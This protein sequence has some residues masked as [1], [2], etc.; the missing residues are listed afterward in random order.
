MQ[1]CHYAEDGCIVKTTNYILGRHFGG[2]PESNL[3]SLDPIT[4]GKVDIIQG[5]ESPVN[6]RLQFKNLNIL[7]LKNARIDSAK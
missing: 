5:P 1:K 2:I 7:G 3:I 4:V 6:V